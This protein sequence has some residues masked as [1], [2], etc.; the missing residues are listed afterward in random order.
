VAVAPCSLCQSADLFREYAVS[1]GVTI[2]AFAKVCGDTIKDIP[3]LYLNLTESQL[4]PNI[5][6]CIRMSKV[7]L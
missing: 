1:F 6:K 4:L 7:I 2:F 3:D 5:L